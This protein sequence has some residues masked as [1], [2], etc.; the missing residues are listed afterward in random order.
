MSKKINIVY[1]NRPDLSKLFRTYIKNHKVS[2]NDSFRRSGVFEQMDDEAFADMVAYWDRVFPGWDNWN[3]CPYDD[4]EDD[5]DVVYPPQKSRRNN[6]QANREEGWSRKKKHKHSKRKKAKVID[7]NT[8]YNG[9]NDDSDNEYSFD[10]ISYDEIPRKV[11]IWFYPDYHDCYD[12]LE[13]DSLSDFNDYCEDMGYVI[14]ETVADDLI[15]RS[16]S[17]C[18]VDRLMERHGDLEIVGESSYGEM[19]YAVAEANELA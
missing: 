13:F 2:R 1:S 17:H 9:F 5:C 8:P 7:I 15:Y 12:R 18:C 3:R 4:E 14:P 11:K 19:F 16:E 6:W 10:D